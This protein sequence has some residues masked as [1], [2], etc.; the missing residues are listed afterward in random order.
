MFTKNSSTRVTLRLLAVLTVSFLLGLLATTAYGQTCSSTRGINYNSGS[1]YFVAPIADHPR[2]NA[3]YPISPSQ[4][5]QWTQFN[6]RHSFDSTGLVRWNGADSEFDLMQ[7][8]RRVP[9]GGWTPYPRST[10]W[11]E[12][13][14]E[15]LERQRQMAETSFQNFDQKSQQQIQMMSQIMRR[16][17]KM[18]R[19]IIRRMQ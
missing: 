5:N 14:Q 16:K 18:S 11:V 3:P 1:T 13:A 12:E 8:V 9:V 4:A 6:Q 15:E 7:G 10:S 17:N 19:Q 2:M